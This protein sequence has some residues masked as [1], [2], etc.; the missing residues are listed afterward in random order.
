ME[1]PLSSGQR[2][3]QCRPREGRKLFQGPISDLEDQTE[4]GDLVYVADAGFPPGN[5]RVVKITYRRCCKSFVLDNG[6]TVYCSQAK[7]VYPKFVPSDD[8]RKRGKY[9]LVF[10]MTTGNGEWDIFSTAHILPLFGKNHI[11]DK[12]CWCEPRPHK[13][14][15]G[16]Y[17]LVHK[18]NH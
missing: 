13:S 12:S 15:D 1:A 8:E 4:V 2:P 11:I 5:Y 3:V 16:T 10:E 6:A 14:D 7:P 18:A 17:F 9:V